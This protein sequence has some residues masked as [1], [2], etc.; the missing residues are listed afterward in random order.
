MKDFNLAGM[1]KTGTLIWK[2]IKT[3]LQ[4]HWVRIKPVFQKNGDLLLFALAIAVLASVLINMINLKDN[5]VIKPPEPATVVFTQW[6]QDNL[7]KETLRNLAEE[8]ES[9][10]SDIKIVIKD[11]SYEELRNDLFHPSEAGFPGDVLALDPLWVPELIEREIIEQGNEAPF[12]SFINVLYYNIEILKEAG[13]AMP[14]KNRNEF[15]NCL[16]AITAREKNRRGLAMDNKS[17]RW[18]HD[19]IFPW[20]WSAGAQLITEGKPSVNTRPVVE[21]LSYLASLNKEGLIIPGGQNG[22]KQ[23]NFISGKAAFMIAPSSEIAL[24]REY[25]GDD[26]FGISSIP[27][28]DNYAG[29]AF[30]ASTGW[31]IG[32]NSAS[33]H[34]E[35]ALL[36]AGFLSE[37]ESLLSE[38]AHAI[39]GNGNLLFTRDP[40]YSKL[41]D[42]SIAAEAAPD[43]RGGDA[44]LSASSS[45]VPWIKLEKIFNEELSA[46]FEEKSSAE[47]TA[48]A[49]QE[50]WERSTRQ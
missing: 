1:I 45:G 5:K 10:Y 35:E 42:I 21:S 22:N 32:V 34:K 9:L 18:I 17:S 12:L 4:S 46:L 49:I 28:P 3:T 43:F 37:K 6:W 41:W 47:K 16:K 8:F 2:K 29:R 15:T 33:L 27:S 11:R 14:P 38:K 48:A 7:E 44:R 50:K 19:D 39:P 36:F 30:H 26:A 31:T 23:D 20:I 13:F 40:F 24:I 25:M